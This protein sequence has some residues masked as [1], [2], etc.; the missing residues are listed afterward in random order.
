LRRHR[1]RV[2]RVPHFVRNRRREFTHGGQTI[3][4]TQRLFGA[5]VLLVSTPHS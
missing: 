3:A 5:C 1:D 2:E 4:T